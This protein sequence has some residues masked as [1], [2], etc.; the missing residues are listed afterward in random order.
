MPTGR[1]TRV[2]SFSAAHRYFRPDWTAER[3]AE[4]F[5]R[6]AGEHGHG[7]NYRCAVTVTGPVSDETGMIVD[8]GLLDR[9]LDE[10][11]RR[12]LD[13]RHL[14]HE[15]AEFAYGRQIPTVEALAMWV[16]RRVAP[17]LPTGVRLHTVRVEEDPHLYAEYVGDA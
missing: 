9:V 13:H 5:G 7:H 4:V 16:W 8:L 3:N 15:V 10:E 17:R 1:L 11:V 12:P 2:V 14:N 6:C